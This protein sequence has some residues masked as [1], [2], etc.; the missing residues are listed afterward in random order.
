MLDAWMQV[1]DRDLAYLLITEP[2]EEGWTPVKLKFA[3]FAEVQA[4]EAD[5]WVAEGDLLDVYSSPGEEEID[6]AN[7]VGVPAPVVCADWEDYLAKSLR[8]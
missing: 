7:E 4:D 6:W 2:Q 8:V 3:S 1:E 5:N